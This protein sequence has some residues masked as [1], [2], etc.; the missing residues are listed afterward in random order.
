MATMVNQVHEGVKLA[1][2]AGEAINQIKTGS[3]QTADTVGEISTA[4]NEQ[5]A[6]SNDIATHIEKIS[7]LTERNSIAAET[8]ADAAGHLE[9]LADDM[10]TT[11]NRFK[12]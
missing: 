12:I 10:Q 3:G 4:L 2:Q 8:A 5:T 11:I 1:E 7:Q 9:R 6:A